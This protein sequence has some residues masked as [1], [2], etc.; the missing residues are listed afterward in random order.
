[1]GDRLQSF[2]RPARKQ[3]AEDRSRDSRKSSDRR[4]SPH[5]LGDVDPCRYGRYRAS[6]RQEGALMNR[7]TFLKAGS[8]LPLGVA[9]IAQKRAA[10]VLKISLNAYSFNK[11]LNDNIRGRGE[12]VT[13]M[14]LV[15]FCAKYKFDAIDPTGY[16]FPGYPAA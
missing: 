4:E 3:S 10:P 12:G 7:R 14:Q 13:L 1:M 11:L 8:L 2:S 9:A 15:D 6:S 5:E 16:F